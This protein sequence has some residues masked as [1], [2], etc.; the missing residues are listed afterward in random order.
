LWGIVKKDRIFSNIYNF[1][2][3]VVDGIYYNLYSEL[4][5]STFFGGLK[6]YFNRT[7]LEWAVE[8]RVLFWLTFFCFCSLC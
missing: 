6:M 3:V 5:F 4:E 1:M 7:Q 2:F 8:L